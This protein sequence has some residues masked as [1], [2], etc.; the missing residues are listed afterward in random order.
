VY[1][2]LDDGLTIVG[3]TVAVYASPGAAREE[4]GASSPSA[5]RAATAP[6]RGVKGPHRRFQLPRCS[7]R[8]NLLSAE[9][10]ALTLPTRAKRHSNTERFGWLN[11]RSRPP[12]PGTIERHPGV[13]LRPCARAQHL[14]RHG[15]RRGLGLSDAGSAAGLRQLEPGRAHRGA[16]CGKR[17]C[18]N[19]PPD[20]GAARARGA[21][22][23]SRP[24]RRVRRHLL[25]ALRLEVG[26]LRRV[27]G[28]GR[29]PQVRRGPAARL[30]E[31]ARARTRAGTRS[32]AGTH[33]DTRPGLVA[34]VRD[35]RRT[36]G[37]P[38]RRPRD[39]HVAAVLRRAH[40]VPRFARG[41]GLVSLCRHRRVDAHR[42]TAR[43]RLS[44]ARPRSVPRRAHGRGYRERRR[45]RRLRGRRRLLRV[46]GGGERCR[47][48]GRD[49]A[50]AELAELAEGVDLRAR[51]GIHTGAALRTPEG[52]RG[53]RS[54]ARPG[55][56]P[57]PT[58]VRS[59]S[60]A[61]PPTFST[62]RTA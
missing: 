49:P 13:V 26:R 61:Q 6:R 38:A 45:C 16:G 23:P 9:L 3:L 4:S 20:T 46:L 50:V 62:E 41:D 28:R 31:A 58:A 10:V 40:G 47:R 18:A 1:A 11:R 17:C 42:P 22:G 27:G 60:R 30:R 54:T 51:I 19:A 24:Q 59:S 53:S 34:D 52:T 55:S 36:S 32:A 37:A 39:A 21:L 56:V 8:G 2:S 15:G 57:R 5:T 35:T 14:A 7:D 12:P 48:G 33:T 29:V 44:R 25:A 43:R